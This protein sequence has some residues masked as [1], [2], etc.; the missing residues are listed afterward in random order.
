MVPPEA[1]GWSVVGG[2]GEDSSSVPPLFGR[3]GAA[4][5]E[6]AAAADPSPWARAGGN[7]FDDDG[8]SSIVMAVGFIDRLMDASVCSLWISG[9]ALKEDDCGREI[10]SLSRI[11]EGGVPKIFFPFF[12]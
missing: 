1:V 2:G 6:L 8:S 9:K 3:D 12:V 5:G 7:D 10:H 4:G 11:W